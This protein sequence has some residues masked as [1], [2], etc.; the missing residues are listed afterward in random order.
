MNKYK[1][2]VMSKQRIPFV[3]AIFVLLT[4]CV[5][6]RLFYLQVSRHD[7]YHVIASAQ[8]SFKDTIPAKRGQIFA[9][10]TISGTPTLL[11]S[12]QTLDLVFI[13]PKEIENKE[14]AITKLSEILGMK[15][16]EIEPKFDDQA[17][18]VIV[19]HKLTKAESDRTTEANIKGVYLQQENWRYYPENTMAS[20]ILGFVT[21]EGDGNYGIEQ[22]FNDILKGENGYLSEETDAHG[23][24]IAFGTDGSTPAINGDDVYLTI[25]R[26]IQGT[27]EKTL[28]DT[29]KK[30]SADSGQIIVLEKTTGKV[31][32]L[33]NAPVF[34]PN[35]Y[36]D[37]KDF[38]V[39]KN[40]AVT[41]L[42]EPGS[43]FKAVTLAAGE[44]S[45]KI[46]PETTYT[47]TGSVVLNGN[48]IKNS[49]LKAHGVC[50]MSYVLEASLNTGTTFVEQLLGKD[51]FFDYIKKFGFGE[52]TG[53]EVNGEAGGKVYRPEELNDHGYATISFGQSI[54]A[55]A[56]QMIQ[57]YTTIANNGVMMKPYMVE[58]TVNTKGQETKTNAKEIRRVISEKAAT[59]MQQMLINV[60]EKGHGGQAKVAGYRIAG[61]TGTAQVVKPDGTGYLDGVNIGT[62]VG[63]PVHDDANFVVLAKI[64]N[65]KG[66]QWAESTAA[67]AVGTMLDYLLKYYQIPPT[68][69]VQ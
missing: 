28:A 8:H 2:P 44:D 18:Y 30:F 20:A 29:L 32:A 25:D 63:F 43:V 27:A 36:T 58:K 31:L 56:L 10:D 65:P 23:V 38:S 5:Y 47:D 9:Y 22:Y 37:V 51:L 39:F 24:K 49:D 60:V 41:D 59:E 17:V 52:P 54:S 1:K 3:I 35:K 64:D 68:E 42:Y 21:A 7:S 57:A 45:G 4:F 66:V 13:N 55:T 50:T 15:K 12:N 33:A 61:K 14:E 16:E 11:A 19:K 69:K 34:D 46:T 26:Y 67:P 48:A 6:G 40:K 62:F 53:I